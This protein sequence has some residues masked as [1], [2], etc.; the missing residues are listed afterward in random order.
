MKDFLAW[1]KK[2]QSNNLL[3]FLTGK[4]VFSPKCF[5]WWSNIWDFII[6]P[7]HLFNCMRSLRRKELDCTIIKFIDIN[8]NILMPYMYFHTA[9]QPTKT[10][11]IPSEIKIQ[12]M[13]RIAINSMILIVSEAGL[14]V[15]LFSLESVFKL[16]LQW[17][18]HITNQRIR[19][20]HYRG[21]NDR[22][23]W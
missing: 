3:Y 8:L 20:L 16:N 1:K 23:F 13:L 9:I 14:S 19:K 21:R 2:F 10:K 11:K 12:H 7:I 17:T 5:S 18:K 15:K 4:A 22:L 6:H